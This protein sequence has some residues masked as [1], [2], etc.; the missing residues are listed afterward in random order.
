MTTAFVTH[1][2]FISHDMPGH[3]EH[4]G[5]LKSV[6][7]K[8]EDGNLRD[9][10][11]TLVPK[12]LDE[13]T[14]LLA[15]TTRHVNMLGQI[16]AMSDGP[17]YMIDADTY[18]TPDSYTIARIGAGAV[19]MAVDTVLDGEADH[20]LVAVRP[21]GHHAT[22]S[23]PMGFCLLN[24]VAIAARHAQKVHNLQ[25]VLIVDYDVHHGNGTNDI[26]YEDDSV[27]FI[28]TH[29]FPLY[30][31]S[32]GLNDTGRGKGD[33]YTMNIPVRAGT[34]DKSMAR[35]YEEVI[36]KA[37]ERYQP[38]L[39]IVSAGFDAH[40]ADPL[41]GLKFTL[42]GYAHLTRELI[43]MAES[44]CDGNIVFAMEGG[45]DLEVI[46]TGM[47]NVARCLLGDK[48][49]VDTMGEPKDDSEPDI[50]HLIESLKTVHELD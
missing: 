33:G 12:P 18:M 32:G 14:I 28:S 29:Q 10:M 9:R 2:R 16:E 8:I 40:H 13:H 44:V 43:R 41:A 39:I 25:R 47:A 35:L 20:A 3:P 21:P 19:C 37:V 48:D 26:F 11:F 38:Q 4:A 1:K 42:T 15:H 23:T 50:N 17:L 6:W 27:Y 34:G 46:G 31:G 22:A 30:P 45:Y 24:N 36:W 49:I 7:R 5:R